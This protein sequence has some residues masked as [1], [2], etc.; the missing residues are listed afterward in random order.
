MVYFTQQSKTEGS[1]EIASSITD[2]G[3]RGIGNNQRHF[4]FLQSYKRA[5]I[6]IFSQIFTKVDIRYE[7]YYRKIGGRVPYF[8]QSEA[9]K[10]CFLVSDWLKYE[11][12][13]RKFRAL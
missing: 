12:L 2:F 1:T 6:T 8:S 3:K 11:A 5:S 9:R 10:G 7:F 4:V 13:P